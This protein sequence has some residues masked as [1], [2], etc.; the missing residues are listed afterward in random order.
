MSCLCSYG[1][2]LLYKW[3]PRLGGWLLGKVAAVNTDAKI[4]IAGEMCNFRVYYPGDKQTAEH[5]LSVQKYA[6]SKK[7]GLDSWVVLGSGEE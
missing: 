2:A 4:V 1:H 5:C 3:P 6:G 7:A